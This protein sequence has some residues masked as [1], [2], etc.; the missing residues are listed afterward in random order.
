MIT[1]ESVPP[2]LKEG[3]PNY[4]ISILRRLNKNEGVLVDVLSLEISEDI[5]FSVLIYAFCNTLLL[6]RKDYSSQ[7][8]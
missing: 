4:G 1:N 6:R 5:L 8:I 2:N 7:K 3:I